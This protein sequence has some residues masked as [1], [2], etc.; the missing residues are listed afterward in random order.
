LLVLN[1]DGTVY[2][3]YFSL[4]EAAKSLQCSIKTISITLKTE[5]KILKKR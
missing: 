4:T 1:L 3:K 2:Y 5:K